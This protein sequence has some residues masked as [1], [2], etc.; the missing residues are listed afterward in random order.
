[1]CDS[2]SDKY[3]AH[4]VR[5]R[6]RGIITS[7]D[8]FKKAFLTCLPG[9]W[10]LALGEP[11]LVRTTPTRHA[12][13]SI[14]F[15]FPLNTHWCAHAPATEIAGPAFSGSLRHP[16]QALLSS[17]HNSNPILAVG[18]DLAPLLIFMLLEV[19]RSSH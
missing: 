16:L 4:I 12:S 10:K 9:L 6:H 14:F 2:G 18:G 8:V 13:S 17:F 7:I 19:G 11:Y 1:V 3:D 15:L 5:D